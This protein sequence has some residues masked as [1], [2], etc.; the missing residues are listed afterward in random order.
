MKYVIVAL[1]FVLYSFKS[2]DTGCAKLDI[3]LIADMSGSVDGY[4][5]YIYDALFDFANNLELD[6]NGI[7]IGLTVFNYTDTILYHLDDNK[8]K[9]I[10]AIHT[11]KSTSADGG[12]YLY[13]TLQHTTQEFIKRGRQDSKWIVIIITD[14][15]P[16]QLFDVVKEAKR[17]HSL[18]IM[19]FGVMVESKEEN[20]S[21]LRD[22]S[23]PN[24][25]ISTNYQLLTEELK[26][27]DLC[28]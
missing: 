11:I 25:Y 6:E 15:N 9:L 21:A 7:R 5:G 24:C 10:Q 8:P 2:P 22:I 12:T 19:I 26:K 16:A 4:Q 1:F 3:M 18:G 17:M 20:E 23:S 27:L 13:T 14:G 28:L